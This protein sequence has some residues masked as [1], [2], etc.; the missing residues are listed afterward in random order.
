MDIAFGD[1]LE[2]AFELGIPGLDSGNCALCERR[3]LPILPVRYAVCRRTRLNEAV[4]ALSPD[5]VREFTEITLDKTLYSETL[6]NRSLSSPAKEFL[7]AATE[8]SVSKYVLRKMRS[9][10]FYMLEESSRTP[11]TWYAYAVTSDGM[12]YQ[13][14]AHQSPPSHADAG[15]DCGGSP[16][17]E[18]RTKALNASLVTLG[19]ADATTRLYFAFIEHPW[20]AAHLDRLRSTPELRSQV[21]QQVDLRSWL[22]G[23]AQPHAFGVD[24]LNMVAE[25]GDGAYAMESEFWP[26]HGQH[27]WIT[28]D[29]LR[30]IM[31]TRGWEHYQGR[32]LILAVKDELG[33]IEELNAAR[34]EPLQ[35]IERF[36]GEP[37]SENRRKLTVLKAVDA[38]SQHF[39]D[40]YIESL[41]KQQANAT[42]RLEYDVETYDRT[43][44]SIDADIRRARWQGDEE[45]VC[46]HRARRSAYINR[47]GS[48]AKAD[49]ERQETITGGNRQRVEERRQR[50]DDQLPRYY[51]EQA[52]AVFR[53]SYDAKVELTRELV[54]SFD[55]DYALWLREHLR[56]V[57]N[58]YSDADADYCH[59]LG[60]G[61][62]VANALSGG[63]FSPASACI[64]TDFAQELDNETSLLRRVM[65]ANV[66]SLVS[67]SRRD[68]KEVAGKEFFDKLM[69]RQWAGVYAS[70]RDQVEVQPEQLEKRFQFATAALTSIIGSALA[71]LSVSDFALLSME[72][73]AQVTAGTST[74]ADGAT[75]DSE[76]IGR[77]ALQSFTRYCQL[78]CMGQLEMQDDGA[79]LPLLEKLRLRKR[80]YYAWLEGIPRHLDTLRRG[81]PRTP[82]GDQAL[83]YLNESPDNTIGGNFFVDTLKGEGA[84]DIVVPVAATLR[85][86]DIDIGS[87]DT[88]DDADREA[89][90]RQSS[91]AIAA[92]ILG[93]TPVNKS[94]G[95]GLVT[96]NATETV[97][98]ELNKTGDSDSLKLAAAMVN[99]AV[100]SMAMAEGYRQ[101][102]GASLPGAAGQ[103]PAIGNRGWS[104]ANVFFTQLGNAISMMDAFSKIGEAM[105]ARRQGMPLED[106]GK[107]LVEALFSF[108]SVAV[109]LLILHPI[110]AAVSSVVLSLLTGILGPIMQLLVPRACRTWLLRS[111]LGKWS[112]GG[113]LRGQIEPFASAAE[114]MNSLEL[115]FRGV[116]VDLVWKYDT[117]T[118]PRYD[119]IR[120][121]LEENPQE[122]PGGDYLDY[123]LDKEI[124]LKVTLPKLDRVS[125]TVELVGW[126]DERSG[127]L[128]EERSVYR[129]DFSRTHVDDSFSVR[130]VSGRAATD[131][132]LQE[133]PSVVEKGG[134]F[135]VE[136][137]RAISYS[138]IGM[139]ARLSIVLMSSG[140]ETGIANDDFRIFF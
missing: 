68:R 56:P 137:V 41:E 121:E 104:M 38:F 83:Q 82:V 61:G 112:R 51:D 19:A 81:R 100:A 15:F 71:A 62:L 79:K 93:A 58:R 50:F 89:D 23:N 29:N 26:S 109:S 77:G 64:W 128:S 135:L 114:E 75:R 13:F 53:Q 123:Q 37:G 46:R 9:G 32:G 140:A 134:G 66:Q 116:T 57:V 133:L 36:L 14:N 24:D 103:T 80:D 99:L 98:K 78:L 47:Y 30:D 60:I 113:A 67:R 5:R 96:W 91:R 76:K 22:A 94:I 97:L 107:P 127:V 7:G 102:R 74:K 69:L 18:K 8:S 27:Q 101:V 34:Q 111:C 118:P 48:R 132:V 45:A 86:L 49:R 129:Y 31:Q 117:S 70:V 119:F 106:Q 125:L 73:S 65:F 131:S 25:Y 136:I 28:G 108:A 11:P 122:N 33:V 54:S 17:E 55:S 20:S 72:A 88:G 105:K 16:A 39:E 63:I 115:V 84:L 120:G 21:M 110:A 40:H 59:G 44:A 43:V 130:V 95:A 42:D 2:R 85:G 126:V 90:V 35:I 124:S 6:R 4:T 3:G 139:G 1:V 87:W 10:Y 138:D 52:L 12:F 92:S